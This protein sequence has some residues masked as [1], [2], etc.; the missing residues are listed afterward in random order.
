MVL[1]EE[2]RAARLRLNRMNPSIALSVGF[3]AAVVTS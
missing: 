3:S 1:G 2:Q